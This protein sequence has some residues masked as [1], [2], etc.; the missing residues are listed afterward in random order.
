[1]DPLVDDALQPATPGRLVRATSKIHAGVA[2]TG[3]QIVG[4]SVYWREGSI[5]ALTASDPV[6]VVLGDSLGQG[7]GASS[8]EHG[9]VGLLR[10]AMS[11]DLGSPVAV[12]NLSRSGARINDVLSTQLPALAAAGVEPM[13]TVCTV[14]GNDL[15][16]SAWPAKVRRE[17]RALARSLPVGT[18]WATVPAKGSTMAKLLNR[19]IRTEAAAQNLLVADIGA[20]LT[21]WRGKLAK[22]GFHPSDEGHQ[23]WAEQ[24][25]T[26]AGLEPTVD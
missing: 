15:L 23:F 19:R 24:F 26:A 7:I 13:L 14:G 21:S 25:E 8:P 22:D 4:Y 16:R 12:L 20:N 6:L 3:E 1:M 18:V 10:N 2:T 9:Y 5:N 17:V 11:I